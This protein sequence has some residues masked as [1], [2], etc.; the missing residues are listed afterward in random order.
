MT[1]KE[2]TSTYQICKFSIVNLTYS[3]H[4]SFQFLQELVHPFLEE[5]KVDKNVFT[6]KFAPGK[7]Q[8]IEPRKST[9]TPRILALNCV[10]GDDTCE[11]YCS[12]LKKWKSYPDLKSKAQNNV[13]C[14]V[15]LN[16]V[17]YIFENLMEMTV[18]TN[19]TFFLKLTLNQSPAIGVSNVIYLEAIGQTTLLNISKS[20]FTPIIAQL[21]GHKVFLDLTKSKLSLIPLLLF[22]KVHTFDFTTAKARK[23]E[24][25]RDARHDFAAIVMHDSIY[26]AGGH[27]SST[28]ERYFSTISIFL[29]D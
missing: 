13:C 28:V 16:D 15:I 1:G 22:P 3:F 17:L 14:A 5:H 18:N 19:L 10:P 24:A 20:C 27:R 4:F 21:H 12:Q 11:V 6:L 8:V 29:F 26:I 23:I 25:P 2:Q 9:V 7:K